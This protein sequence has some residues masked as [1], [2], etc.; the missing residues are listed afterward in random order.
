MAGTFGN[1]WATL[2]FEYVV[3]G[4]SS[5]EMWFLCASAGFVFVVGAI[6]VIMIVLYRKM[7]GE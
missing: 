3:R 7:N 2:Y 5:L 1:L 6:S 4:D